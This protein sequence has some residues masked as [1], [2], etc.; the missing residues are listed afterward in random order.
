MRRF[1]APHQGVVLDVGILVA[2]LEEL[3]PGEDQDRAEDQEH[4]R[5]VGQ[6]GGADRDEDRPQDQRQGDAQRE[7]LVPVLGRDGERRHDD[8]ED[9]QVVDRQGLL[10]DVPGEVLRPVRRP[11]PRPEHEAED[12]RHR[13]VED[14][15]AGRL[16]EPD[17][18]RV[19]AADHQVEGEQGHDDA[20]RQRP[21]LPRDAQGRAV[22]RRLG[23]ADSGRGECGHDVERSGGPGCGTRARIRTCSS[24]RAH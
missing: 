3:D 2:V 10:D 23:E 20:Q 19:A 9:E 12:D 8:H 5:E 21:D 13:D 11:G 6:Q 24:S 22:A 17:G 16:L 15:P 4:E 1:V 18:V 7:Q 14:R